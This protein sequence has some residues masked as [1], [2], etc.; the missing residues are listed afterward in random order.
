MAKPRVG[1][2]YIGV[3]GG[4]LIVNDQGQI[5]LIKRSATCRNEAGF[6]SKPGGTL[7]FGEKIEDMVVRECREEVGVEVEI[8]EYLTHTEHFV[9]DQKEHWVSFNYLV[10]IISGE[11]SNL[12][13]DRHDEIGWFDLD[14]LPD[15]LS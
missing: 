6:W 4:A 11:P 13:P 3:G 8:V 7:E 2:D 5:L 14:N 12:E 9:E 10:K 15:K 1:K